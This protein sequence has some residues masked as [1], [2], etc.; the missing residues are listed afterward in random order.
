MITI[1]AVR[2]GQAAHNT[3]HIFNLYNDPISHLTDK[4]VA[5][6]EQAARQLK[7]AGIT[8]IYSSELVRAVETADIIG[9]ATGNN[10]VVDPRINEHNSGRH[11]KSTYAWALYYVLTGLRTD[12]KLFGGES[13]NP[14]SYT[15]L[16]LPTTS[17]V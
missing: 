6:A 2:H 8:H 16:T 13:L 14:V 4:G 12:A 10:A 9:N 11:G 17:R 7:N 5:Q 3:K 1:Y 15:H